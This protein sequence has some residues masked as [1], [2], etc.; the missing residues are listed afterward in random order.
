MQEASPNTS[1]RNS[2]EN[3]NGRL[4]IRLLTI[5]HKPDSS[6]KQIAF[7][8]RPRGVLTLRP[9]QGLLL[10]GLQ[11]NSLSSLRE[12]LLKPGQSALT[13]FL[14]SLFQS[15]SSHKTWALESG[16]S[17]YPFSFWFSILVIFT[18]LIH[19][20][21][22]PLNVVSMLCRIVSPLPSYFHRFLHPGITKILE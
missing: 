18:L 5:F 3:I 21:E 10:I 17:S 19:I 6:P 12:R 22:H 11:R 13:A 2:L 20:R 9:W 14:N 4:A 1:H 15:I 8:T 16:L 7:D